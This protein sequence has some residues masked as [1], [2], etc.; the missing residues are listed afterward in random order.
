MMKKM[1]MM[2]KMATMM[3]PFQTGIYVW[4]LVEEI[5]AIIESET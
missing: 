4:F 1:M 5:I 2:M 3:M